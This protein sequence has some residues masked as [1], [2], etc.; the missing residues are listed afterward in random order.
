[1]LQQ[2]IET[3]AIEDLPRSNLT[4]L[5]RLYWAGNQLRPGSPVFN[6][7]LTFTIH[8]R[9]E[10]AHFR[11]AFE[12]TIEASDA[13]RTQIR[14]VDG[15]PCRIVLPRLAYELEYLDFTRQASPEQAAR[16][17]I[18]ERSQ[19]PIP[20]GE[21]PFDSALLRTGREEFT[22]YINQHH[23]NSDAASFFLTFER[24]AEFYKSAIEG[25]EL[26]TVGRPAFEEYARGEQ[27][28]RSSRAFE[29]A[30]AYWEQKL[31]PGPDPIH[32]FGRVPTRRTTRTQRG[33]FD[34]GPERSRQLSQLARQA[35]IYSV[36]EDLTLY[37][38]FC[39]LF[40]L[41]LRRVSGNRRIGFITP[42][43]NRFNER[44]RNTVGL[45]MELC[46]LQVEFQEEDTFLSLLQKVRRETRETL[47]YYQ[48]GS[49]L[50]LKNQ[51]FEVMFNMHHLPDLRI[52]GSEVTIERIHPG[53]GSESLALHVNPDDKTG[54]I[55]LHFDFHQDVFSP[56]ESEFMIQAFLLLIDDILEQAESPEIRLPEE[57]Q[58]REMPKRDSTG[59][60]AL[61]PAVG[62][63]A[64]E[65]R[66]SPARDEVEE[67]LVRIW[68]NVL[69]KSPVGIH[70]DFLANWAE[71]PGRPS[72]SS[73]K[74]RLQPGKTCP[75]RRC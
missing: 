3:G 57:R 12:A 42:V 54:S 17:W 50:S 41:L 48:A 47:S 64:R 60:P 20:L 38:I 71:A 49:S 34:L 40:T 45:V 21:R 70:D 44:A 8:S 30:T 63:P 75:W 11:R 5:Q 9:I 16:G 35:R 4:G 25:E 66:Y 27:A 19:V 28:Y 32:F 18:Q 29:R 74:S 65:A 68:E 2:P 24:L 15:V 23:I 72:K 36:S 14:E 59:E 51:A 62:P 37:V 13:L 33:S 55:L 39:S 6:T 1:M 7:I 56:E 73:L 31:N 46:P 43:H 10:P 53:H 58:F 61:V 52:N 26:S 69:G 22:W 67:A